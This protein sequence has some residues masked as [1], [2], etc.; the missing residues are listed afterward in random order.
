[1]KSETITIN[2]FEINYFIIYKTKVIL[3]IVYMGLNNQY[4]TIN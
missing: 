3:F 2:I 4:N 1:M